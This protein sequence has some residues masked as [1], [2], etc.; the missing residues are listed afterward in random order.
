MRRGLKRCEVSQ[1]SL[2]HFIPVAHSIYEAAHRGWTLSSDPAVAKP[3]FDAILERE[4][5]HSQVRHYWVARIEGQPVAYAKVIVHDKVEADYTALKFDPEQLKHYPSYAMIHEMNRF[6]LQEQGFSYVND[7]Q[8]SIL[9]DTNFQEFLV[10]DL[11]FERAP[12]KLFVHYS[13]AFGAGMHLCRALRGVR[14]IKSNPKVAAL[15]ELHGC[16]SRV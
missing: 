1:V 13:T 10:K 5:G 7:G 9:H 15:L 14:R 11:L 2:D 3:A 4:R 6:Y 8:R 16:A 12:L